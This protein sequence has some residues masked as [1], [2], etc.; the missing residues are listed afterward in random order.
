MFKN[1]YNAIME[2]VVNVKSDARNLSS[3]FCGGVDESWQLFFVNINDGITPKVGQHTHF[4][5]Y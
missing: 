4:I 5:F 3:F 1:V 2:L